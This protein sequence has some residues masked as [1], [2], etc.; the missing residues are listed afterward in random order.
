M[1]L[2]ED[3]VSTDLGKPHRFLSVLLSF[4]LV[5]ARRVLC[6][7][8]CDHRTGAVPVPSAGTAETSQILG[9]ALGP[10][11][12]DLEGLECVQRRE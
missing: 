3:S 11:R 2:C 10:H 12:K 1:E 4:L 9:A 7:H 6:L 5:W 8:W